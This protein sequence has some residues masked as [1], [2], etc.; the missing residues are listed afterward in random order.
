MRSKPS[1][2]QSCILG[3]RSFRCCLGLNVKGLCRLPTAHSVSVAVLKSRFFRLDTAGH[4]T[5]R[6]GPDVAR[7]PDV[8]HHWRINSDT[9]S[10]TVVGETSEKLRL[11]EPLYKWLNTIQ[12]VCMY[13]IVYINVHIC[14][15]YCMYI[16]YAYNV[17]VCM[18]IC[19]Y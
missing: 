1:W 18:Y 19:T 8:V 12:Y 11:R 16:L 9:V 10:I 13:D 14:I 7:G 4:M 15:I 6:R 17:C 3:L 2:F 5:T